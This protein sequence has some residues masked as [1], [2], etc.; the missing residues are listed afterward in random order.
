[1]QSRGTASASDG[2]PDTGGVN[3]TKDQEKRL[4]YAGLRRTVVRFGLLVAAAWLFATFSYCISTNDIDWF[5]RSG[6]LMCLVGAVVTFRLTGFYQSEMA[7]ALKDGLVSVPREIALQL[8]PPLSYV[9]LSYFGYL[10]GVVG[11]AVWGY[12]DLLHR[13]I[14]G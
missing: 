12:G 4:L 8:N 5:S 7:T 13:L 9:V 3:A 2:P 11:T 14:A 6:S 10:T 1:M